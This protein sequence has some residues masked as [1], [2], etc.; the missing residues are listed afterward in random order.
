MEPSAAEPSRH[1]SNNRT[2]GP[3]GDAATLIDFNAFAARTRSK[4]DG[5]LMTDLVS[6]VMR[7]L[8]PELV[9][10]ISSA[11][12]L[13]RTS[14]QMAIEAVVPVVLSALI[15]LADKPGGASR[16]ARAI[17]AQPS[18]T[19]SSLAG[20]LDDLS[21]LEVRGGSVLSALLGESLVRKMAWIVGSYTGI[22][23]GPARR[24]MGLLTPVVLGTVGRVRRVSNLGAEGL[25]RL[26]S[27]ERQKITAAM[28]PGLAELLKDELDEETGLLSPSS[29]HWPDAGSLRHSTIQCAMSHGAERDLP[30]GEWSAW[31]L[32]LLIVLGFVWWYSLIW[33]LLLPSN[34]PRVAETTRTGQ[35]LTATAQ[36]GVAS[37]FIFKAGDDWIS[38]NGYLNKR[39]YDRAGEELGT[40]EDVLV[41]PD[42]K[43]NAAIIAIHRDH[44][45]GDKHIAVPFAALHL[46]QRGPDTRLIFDTTRDALQK[47]P[48]FEARPMSQH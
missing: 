43:F 22:G 47:A 35:T 20:E 21:E 46:E 41:G 10:K 5:G 29:L 2:R 11:A 44:G 26:L 33:W 39:I 38:I 23:E 36:N 13:D 37:T 25:S 7:L 1:S 40:I 31:A 45:L 17:A 3:T 42:G 12:D 4:N 28:P 8:T 6:A 15:D 9:D 27:N 19:P 32:P 34:P 24:L 48:M 18:E 16:L 14:G 30:G